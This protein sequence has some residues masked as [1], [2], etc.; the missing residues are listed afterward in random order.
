MLEKVM[1]RRQKQRVEK[2]EVVATPNGNLVE[3]DGTAWSTL[4]DVLNQSTST[5]L[6]KSNATS[7][8]TIYS[9]VNVLSDDIAKLP[10]KTYKKTK[11]VINRKA[12]HPLDYLLTKRPNEYQ[13]P[14]SFKKAIMVDVLTRGN[15]Y[16]LIEYDD[17]GYPRSLLP[18]AE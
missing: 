6:T 7:F 16:A 2:R 4:V 1:A 3:T 12:D 11:G 13:T 8:N 17:K 9:C 5:S 14:F 18:L 15:G 10:W